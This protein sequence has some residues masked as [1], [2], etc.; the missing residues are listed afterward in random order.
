MKMQKARKKIFQNEQTNKHRKIKN[1]KIFSMVNQT[2][3]TFA[4]RRRRWCKF[5]YKDIITIIII[6]I[7]IIEQKNI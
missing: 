4:L 1:P 7:K 5:I 6:I 3:I 2:H